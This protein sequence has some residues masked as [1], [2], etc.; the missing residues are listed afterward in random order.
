MVFFLRAC[1]LS[2]Y[3]IPFPPR[4]KNGALD[5]HR[6]YYFSISSWL[7]PWCFTLLGST[8][9]PYDQSDLV[10]SECL[11][12]PRFYWPLFNIRSVHCDFPLDRSPRVAHCRLCDSQLFRVTPIWPGSSTLV[13]WLH[14]SFF[15]TTSPGHFLRIIA[16]PFFFPFCLQVA[17]VRADGFQHSCWLLF[18]SVF[19]SCFPAPAWSSHPLFKTL[20]SLFAFFF[21]SSRGLLCRTH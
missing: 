19:F 4:L 6:R 15:S 8:A 16:L 12:P 3:F 18:F 1:T 5:R 20:F 17:A 13:G 14:L 2:F 10:Q 9:I 21:L 7:C 11:G